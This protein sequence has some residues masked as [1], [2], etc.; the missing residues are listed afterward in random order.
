MVRTATEVP[1]IDPFL[2]SLWP[3]PRRAG[4]LRH[5][6]GLN[7]PD[8]S[9][10]ANLTVEK[11]LQIWREN[12]IPARSKFK[13]RLGA[14]AVSSSPEG[15]EWLQGF[16]AGLSA[17]ER[18]KI[19]FLPVHWYG[20]SIT[21]LE[22]Y[23]RS[24]HAEFRKPLWVTE[25]AFVHMDRSLPT[26]PWEV[27]GFLMESCVLLDRLDFVERY[28]WFGAMDE[29]GEWTGR[30]IALSE[31]LGFGQGV[32]RRVGRMYCDELSADMENA[33]EKR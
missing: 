27:E 12:V 20:S 33:V 17:E 21:E 13:F 32:L 26:K 10:Q 6:L 23:L 22:S 18:G 1:N 4:E 19:A 3:L 25:Y 2:S 16:W 31:T 8:V 29:P 7:E 24:M 14:P 11:V 9:S 30:E 5:F 28:A 15:R